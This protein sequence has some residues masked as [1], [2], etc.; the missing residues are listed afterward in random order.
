MI[1]SAASQAEC[2]LLLSERRSAIQLWD[3]VVPVGTHP[4]LQQ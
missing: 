1:P 4:D 2:R 3:L